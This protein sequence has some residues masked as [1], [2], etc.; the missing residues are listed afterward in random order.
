MIKTIILSRISSFFAVVLLSAMLTPSVSLA[1]PGCAERL[2]SV[3]VKD[4]FEALGRNLYTPSR[5]YINECV[6]EGYDPPCVNPKDPKCWFP[7]GGRG[8]GALS[9]SKI[10]Q[11]T[12]RASARC[13]APTLRNIEEKSCHPKQNWPNCN[14]TPGGLSQPAGAG[15]ATCIET[16]A[17]EG[18]ASSEPPPAPLIELLEAPAIQP[19]CTASFTGSFGGSLG[20]GQICGG[21]GAS[22]CG[23]GSISAGGCI[24]N[25]GA[26]DGVALNSQYV[27]QGNLAGVEGYIE[28]IGAE[29]NLLLD[30]YLR[31]YPNSNFI[32]PE[33]GRINFGTSVNVTIQNADGTTTTV[34]M[35]NIS[36]VPGVTV[37]SRPGSTV[38]VT[39]AAIYT[40]TGNTPGAEIASSS[41]NYVMTTGDA[42]QLPN[43]GIPPNVQEN[44][45]AITSAPPPE[46]PA[47]PEVVPPA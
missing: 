31:Q 30:N 15:T 33:G 45:D 11:P 19:A 7:R 4:S 14:G 5:D 23:F 37:I 9:A 1:V 47:T 36:L 29:N 38:I 42:T 32:L 20:S 8:H 43:A 25:D 40:I 44:I 10:Q 22:F 21:V 34:P 28:L 26:E 39:P 16:A 13:P 6:E 2:E 17:G 27:N 35:S 3:N 24:G 41:N 12:G 18:T 46:T